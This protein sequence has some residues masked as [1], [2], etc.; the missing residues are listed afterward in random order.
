MTLRLITRTAVFAAIAAALAP[1]VHAQSTD[2]GNW[3]VRARA[4]YMAP[5]NDDETGLDL[6]VN[7]K[8]QNWC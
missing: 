7:S 3:I 4:L 2:T 6:S 5:A 8:A 1:A